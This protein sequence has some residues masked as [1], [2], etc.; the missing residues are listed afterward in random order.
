MRLGQKKF[1]W[2]LWGGKTVGLKGGLENII[3]GNVGS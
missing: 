2:G 3:K 1:E